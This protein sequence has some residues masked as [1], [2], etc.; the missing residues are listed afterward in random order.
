[1]LG[2][3]TD[4]TIA[5]WAKVAFWPYHLGLRGKLWVQ[6][7]TTTEAHFNEIANGWY[8]GGWPSRAGLLPPGDLAILDCTCELPFK[9]DLPYMVLPIWDTKAP[10]VAQI[11]EGVQWAAQQRKAG[12]TL[13]VHCAHGHGRSPVL[14]CAAMIFE[15]LAKDPRHAEALV[16]ERRPGIHINTQQMEALTS[17][18]QMHEAR[19]T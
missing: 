15:G 13:F 6:R 2:K 19:T 8:L 9:W 16:F 14:M 11:E 10:T 4:G 5:L 3:R 18:F 17:W 12:R 1:M 7:R